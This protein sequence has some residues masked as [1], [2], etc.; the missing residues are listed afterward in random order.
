MWYAEKF[1]MRRGKQENKSG[2]EKLQEKKKK[3]KKTRA[4]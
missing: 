4:G 2:F 3:E 1:C